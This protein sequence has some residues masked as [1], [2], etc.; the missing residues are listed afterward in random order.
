[1]NVSIEFAKLSFQDLAIMREAHFINRLKN[2]LLFDSNSLLLV[3][4]FDDIWGD[5]ADE[6]R[7]GNLDQLS[8]IRINLHEWKRVSRLIL[9]LD[10][11]S[12]SLKVVIQ[13]HPHDSLYL[14]RRKT[15][16]A[17]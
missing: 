15:K 4:L 12:D 3:D 13:A 17:I 16:F 9:L 2:I 10:V 5:K 1:M 11:A 14:L 6:L 7:D 8:R